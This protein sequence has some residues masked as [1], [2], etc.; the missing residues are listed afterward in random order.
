MTPSLASNDLAGRLARLEAADEIRRVTMRYFSLC[1]ALG[2]TT[3]FEELAGLFAADAVWEGRGRYQE[4]FGKHVGREAIIGMLASYAN[5]SHFVLNAHYL[6]SE[7]IEITGDAT[8]TGRWMML[9]VS[10]YQGGRSDL[11][12]AALTLDFV[13]E[14]AAWRIGRFVTRNIFA[15]DVGPWNDEAPISVPARSEPADMPEEQQ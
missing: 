14:A 10:S 12:S 11:R 4:A 6:S 8:A 7:D 5:P 3:P 15:R 2:P 13:R 9:Q 1:D